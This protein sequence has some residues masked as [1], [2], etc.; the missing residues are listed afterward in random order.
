MTAQ[1]LN[2]SH[3]FNQT[4]KLTPIPKSRARACRPAITRI[5][6][7]AWCVCMR[8]ICVIQIE[9]KSTPMSD[10]FSLQCASYCMSTKNEK[11]KTFDRIKNGWW[12]FNG[13]KPLPTIF[14]TDLAAR[15]LCFALSHHPTCRQLCRVPSGRAFAVVS[16][17]PDPFS[18]SLQLYKLNT[19]ITKFHIFI[20]VHFSQQ[21][22]SNN[23]L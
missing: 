3:T 23:Q 15:S 5:L 9:G 6:N 21:P 7:L 13:K 4:Q 2:S 8:I 20:V 16:T 18:F 11:T 19:F 12:P 14:G 1:I 17:F 10:N 22:S